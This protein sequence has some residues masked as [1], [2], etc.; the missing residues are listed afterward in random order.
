MW[1]QITGSIIILLMLS[2]TMPMSTAS[3]THSLEER[4][5]NY[6]TEEEPL[7]GFTLA[8]WSLVGVP[9]AMVGHCTPTPMSTSLTQTWWN[10]WRWYYEL[11][12]L[13]THTYMGN[14][15]VY[16][17][18]PFQGGPQL[19]NYYYEPKK[20]TIIHCPP[21]HYG[22]PNKITHTHGPP[23][24]GGTHGPTAHS[25]I[26]STGCEGAISIAQFTDD[27]DW[28]VRAPRWPPLHHHHWSCWLCYPRPCCCW[29]RG[30]AGSVA[31]DAFGPGGVCWRPGIVGSAGGPGLMGST[32]AGAVAPAAGCGGDGE[33]VQ[34]G[35]RLPM[36]RQAPGLDYDTVPTIVSTGCDDHDQYYGPAEAIILSAVAP[37]GTMV[38]NP[39]RYYARTKRG[40]PP[41]L[42]LPSP[43]Y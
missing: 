7:K 12:E 36:S 28:G 39:H 35:V 38:P 10:W 43:L 42:I 29:A 4:P 9:Y 22:E 30:V 32:A 33:G 26:S 14:T 40:D 19:S 21:N 11:T 13:H 16:S 24:A 5:G 18:P 23:V 34:C 3:T 6:S 25:T 27:G 37:L 31:C 17:W 15:H 1:M 2:S 8:L 20:L 41:P